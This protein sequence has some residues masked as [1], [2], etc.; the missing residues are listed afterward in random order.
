MKHNSDN[1]VIIAFDGA[2]KEL[3]EEFNLESIKQKEFG[4]IDNSSGIKYRYTCELFASFITGETY[5][6]HGVIK[7]RKT[8]KNPLRRSLTGGLVPR[9]LVKNFRGF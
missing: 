6:K 2:D 1:L 4:A 5:E 7:L 3:I 9:Y 8:D